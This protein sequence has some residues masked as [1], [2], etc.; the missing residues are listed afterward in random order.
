MTAS[1]TK[2]TSCLTNLV[3]FDD[4]EIASLEKGRATNV[5]Y[6]DF[7]KVFD[8]VSQEVAEGIGE[9]GEIWR[10]HPYMWS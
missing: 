1:F 9:V 7:C 5:V 4:G 3:A 8:M 6:V 10:H 2:G